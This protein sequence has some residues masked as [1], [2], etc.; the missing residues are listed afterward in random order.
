MRI[1]H[2]AITGGGETVGRDEKR[3]KKSHVS[4]RLYAEIATHVLKVWWSKGEGAMR[5]RSRAKEKKIKT[6]TKK[7][8]KNY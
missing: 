7:E 1:K 8:A 3:Q 5:G 2:F 4:S 6:K